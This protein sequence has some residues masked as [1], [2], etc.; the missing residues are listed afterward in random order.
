MPV[1]IV[2]DFENYTYSYYDCDLDRWNYNKPG[3]RDGYN[4]DYVR[5]GT[6]SMKLINN[7]AESADLLINYDE[8]LDV[9]QEYTISVW[10]ATDK[11]DTNCT[12]SLVQNNYPDYLD[13]VVSVEPMATATGLRVGEW[14]QYT[15]DFKA[16]TNWVSLRFSG[17][18]SIYVDD[19]IVAPKGTIVGSGNNNVINTNNSNTTVG[20]NNASLSPQTADTAVAVIV[21]TAIIACAAIFIISKKNCAEK[22]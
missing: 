5:S 18:S 14:K 9:G 16:Q 19:V 12:M 21:V 10:V 8:W 13:T 15:F 17:N 22:F 20:G 11:A 3:S 2:Q 4:L 1:G 7:S 6:K